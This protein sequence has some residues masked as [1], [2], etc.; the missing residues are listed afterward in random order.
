MC[1]NDDERR[2]AHAHNRMKS[3][4]R[5]ERVEELQG[6]VTDFEDKLRRAGSTTTHTITHNHTLYLSFECTLNGMRRCGV[7][8]GEYGQ[9][10]VD[11]NEYLESR[12]K[13]LNAELAALRE[14]ATASSEDTVHTTR[15][16]IA[17]TVTFGDKD[18]GG[19]CPVSRGGIFQPPL[20]HHKYVPVYIL[21]SHFINMYAVICRS[22]C[23]LGMGS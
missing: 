7:C 13:L 22:C 5:W 16:Y 17:Y 8:V 14:D 10:L 12:L 18:L 3:T 2:Q 4:Q 1:R 11:R 21:I 23:M 19:A 15:D 6:Q 9:Q 20:S